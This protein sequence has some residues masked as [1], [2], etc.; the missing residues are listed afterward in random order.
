MWKKAVAVSERIDLA[1]PRN[2]EP[3]WPWCVAARQKLLWAWKSPF[4]RKERVLFPAKLQQAAR[5]V[6][7]IGGGAT[8]LG[9]AH[10]T[11][12][13]MGHAM[14][15]ARKKSHRAA[16]GYERTGQPSTTTDP[17][18]RAP[19]AMIA[20]KAG[21]GAIEMTVQHKK[22]TWGPA[23]DGKPPKGFPSVKESIVKQPK[24]QDE[25]K[26]AILGPEHGSSGPRE[27]HGEQQHGNGLR[28]R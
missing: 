18:P 16:L 4:S 25:E 1:A 19:E 10:R 2:G 23:E 9:G 26:Q 6:G 15:N 24:Q 14:E 12:K 20:Q 11:Y 5:I 21:Q 27:A 22:A 13:G 17:L 28:T 3:T 7:G 8:A